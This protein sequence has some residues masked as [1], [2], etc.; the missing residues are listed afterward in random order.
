MSDW[1]WAMGDEGLDMIVDWWLIMMSD[2]CNGDKLR[3]INDEW[4]VIDGNGD[5]WWVIF[6]HWC[7]MC[8]ELSF[9]SV[10]VICDEL[11]MMGD[12]RW[13]AGVL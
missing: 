1:W 6:D 4:W 11:W 12:G 5:E 10:W 7:V 9:L 13:V 8:D 3:V 2:W